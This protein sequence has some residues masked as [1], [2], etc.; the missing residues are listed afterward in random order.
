MPLQYKVLTFI[1][2]SLF[3]VWVS[4][5]CL[6]NRRSHGFYRFFGWEA[7]LVLVLLNVEYWFVD[8][9]G[10]FQIVSWPLLTVSL[11]LALHGVWLLK[12]LG[13]PDSNRDAPELMGLEKTTKLVKVG[14]YRYIRHPIYGALVILSWGVFFKHPS[15]VGVSLAMI[16]TVMLTA[17]ARIEEAE[18]RSFFGVEYEDYMKE[19]KMFFPFLF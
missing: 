7:I 1:L 14:A 18:N 2:V 13:E 11:G 10:P 16:A 15:L 9:W 4:R 19:T 12:V 5:A 8:P 17:T 6:A 3:L